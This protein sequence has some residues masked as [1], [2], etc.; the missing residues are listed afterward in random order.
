MVHVPK[1]DGTTRSWGDC[2][3][4]V[5]PQLNVPQYPI[6]LPEDVFVKLQGGQRFTKLDLKSFY[7]QLPLASDSQTFVTINI[8]RGLYR[9]KRLP[10]GIAS[11]PAIFQ[12]TMDVILQGID[13]VASIQ[14]D[15]LIT[16][17]DDDHHIMNLDSVLNRLD[18]YGLRLQLS[19]WKFMQKSVTYM[20]CIILANGISPTEEKI[21]A[22]KQAP[23]PEN[24][25]QLRAFL[26][27]I[28]YYWKFICNLST[29]LQPLNQLLQKNQEFK[30]SS[31]CEQAFNKAKDSLSSS[32]VLVHYDPSLPVI[33]END[34]SQ[35]GIGAVILHRF[36][37]GDERPIAYT[38]RSLNSSGRNYRRIEKEGLAIIFGVTKY[39]MYLFGRKFTLRTDHKPLLKIFAPDSATLVLAAARL[40]RWSLLLSSYHFEIEFKPSAEVASADAL[41]RL[42]LQC[43]NDASVEEEIFFVAS[44]QLNRHPVSAMKIA[45][46]TSRNPTLAKALSLTLDG[47]PLHSCAD[48][49]LKPYFTRKNELSVEQ[50]CLMWGMRTIIPPALVP[51]IPRGFLSAHPGMARMKAMARSHV[52]WPGID[53]DIEDTV[54]ECQQCHR[55]RKAPPASPLLPWSWPTT[56]WRRL[57]LDFATHQSNHYLF[58]VDAHSK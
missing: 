42:P 30:W 6:P 23:R 41:S 11:S 28:N 37:N 54:R 27:M 7:Q 35:Y 55:I 33:L 10:F 40:Q 25:T 9:Y 14:D 26:G 49:Q 4:T 13:D 20:G 19:K 12:R 31:Q 1:S 57:H 44:Q 3:V 34:A 56:P 50:D 2:A 39:Y 24:S 21:E 32:N 58:V 45:K 29:I 43:K 46:E 17:R 8:H 22:I 47:W 52:W 53:S 36:P 5:N 18:S 15:I 48:P 16:G 38:S 51:P